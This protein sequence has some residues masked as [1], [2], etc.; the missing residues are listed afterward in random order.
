[1]KSLSELEMAMRDQR[2]EVYIEA[3][4]SEAEFLRNGTT[5]A[6]RLWA[7]MT[8]QQQS[9]VVPSVEKGVALIRVHGGAALIASRETLHFESQRFGNN[10]EK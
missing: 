7:L 2:F 1:L 3:R 6:Q 8:Q 9:W 5:Q 10:D 4:S